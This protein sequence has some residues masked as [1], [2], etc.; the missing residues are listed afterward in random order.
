MELRVAGFQMDVTNNVQENVE[1]NAGL[2]NKASSAAAD[3]LLTPEGSL[4]GYTPI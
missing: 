2:F 4:S 3:I 1:A